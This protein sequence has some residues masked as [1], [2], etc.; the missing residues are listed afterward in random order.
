MIRRILAIPLDVIGKTKFVMV[1]I[2]KLTC[3]FMY[4]TLRRIV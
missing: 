3:T 1:N 4:I 2:Q